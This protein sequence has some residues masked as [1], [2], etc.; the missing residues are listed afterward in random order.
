MESASQR[1]RGTGRWWYILLTGL[2]ILAVLATCTSSRLDQDLAMTADADTP[3]IRPSTPKMLYE[4]TTTTAPPTTTTTV[5]VPTTT[6]TIPPTTTTVAP[7]TTTSPVTQP[8][9][10]AP[11]SGGRDWDAVAQCESGGNWHINTGNGYYG[12]LQ[13]DLQTWR[14]VGGTGYPHEHS[15]EVQIHHA[16]ILFSQRGAS[17]WPHCGKYL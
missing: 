14:S 9:A 12:G 11:S 4:T 7:T 10:A 13:F 15:R 1:S 6:T 17:P 8:A 5:P 2:V 3:V 16:E